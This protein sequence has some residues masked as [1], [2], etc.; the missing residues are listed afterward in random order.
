MMHVINMFIIA[1]TVVYVIDL[2]GFIQEAVEPFLARMFKMHQVRLKKP[3][4][5]SRCMTLWTTLLYIAITG[6]FTIPTIGFCFLLSFLTPFFNN[7]MI[8]LM[9]W[10]LNLTNGK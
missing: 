10:L 5:C 7:I 9:D 6:H 1:L 4:G 3:W 8:A 2:S